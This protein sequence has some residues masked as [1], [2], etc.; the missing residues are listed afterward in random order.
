MLLVFGSSYELIH[1]EISHYCSL[2]KTA[3]FESLLYTTQCYWAWLKYF[4]AFVCNEISGLRTANGLAAFHGWANSV[5]NIVTFI[6]LASRVRFSDINMSSTT[7]IS[8]QYKSWNTFSCRFTF[9]RQGAFRRM[10]SVSSASSPLQHSTYSLLKIFRISTLS[11][12]LLALLLSV[13][14][15]KVTD[16]EFILSTNSERIFSSIPSVH[17]VVALNW[18]TALPVYVVAFDD[19]IIFLGLVMQQRTFL[20]VVLSDALRS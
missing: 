1:S 18:A 15:C 2:L 10:L 8:F 5:G 14:T 7:V 3:A 4:C 11:N 19:F 17:T 13:T 20:G 12:R 16:P 9:E 6:I